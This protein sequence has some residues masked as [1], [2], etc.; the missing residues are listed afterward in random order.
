[1]GGSQEAVIELSRRLQARGLEVHVYNSCGEDAGDDGVHYHDITTDPPCG[2]ADVR[3]VW[4]NPW[5]LDDLAPFRA[6]RTYLWL[7]DTVPEM[8]VLAREARF[9]RLIVLS[10]FHRS[11]Y[12]RLPDERI[13][14]SRNGINPDHFRSV[15]IDRNPRKVVYGSSYV[16][17][18]DSLLGLW[19]R[20]VREVPDAAL[21]VFYGWQTLWN[22]TRR[23]TLG[24]RKFLRWNP[25][26]YQLFKSRIER[27]MGRLA[28]EHLGRVSHAEVAR[29]FLAAAIWAYPSW[30]PETSCITAMKAQAGGAI[31]V[32]IPNGAL[33]ETVQF[34]RVTRHTSG[35]RAREEWLEALLDL[36]RHPEKQDVER[37]RMMASALELFSWDGVA[38]AWLREFES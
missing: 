11:L 6:R 18:L 4:R 14:H 27:R 9:D 28:V 29:Q 13:F 20:V 30:Y 34:G 35:R 31:P 24:W 12:S 7:Q 15:K 2:P 22:F 5:L 21:T 25:L 17:G 36:L 38:D 26:T 1:V 10:D 3:I 37:Q 8:A 19:G 16:R 32:V 33:A 23:P